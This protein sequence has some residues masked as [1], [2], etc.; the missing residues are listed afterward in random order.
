MGEAADHAHAEPDGEAVSPAGRLQR[1]IPA[2]GVDADRP[3][4]DA[5]VARIAHD[6][7]RRV[8]AYWLRVQERRAADVGVMAF[9]PRR[10]VGDQRKRGR[11]TFRKSVTAKTLQLL[12]GLFGKLRLIAIGDHAGNQL[13]AE[14]RDTARMFEGRHAPSELVGLAWREARAFDG[15]AHRLLLKQRDPQGL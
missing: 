5:M 3:N 14:F 12:E 1:A 6:L 9:E 2:R 8:E 10:G 7:G 15:D 11:V 4:I 13:V